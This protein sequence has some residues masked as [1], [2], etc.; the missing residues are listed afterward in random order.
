MASQFSESNS[1]DDGAINPIPTRLYQV[2]IYHN[3]DRKYPCLVVIGFNNRKTRLLSDQCRKIDWWSFPTTAKHVWSILSNTFLA[4]TNSL[5]GH[6]HILRRDAICSKCSAYIRGFECWRKFKALYLINCQHQ[7]RVF[8]HFVMLSL[9]PSI[10]D[11]VH[12]N[13]NFVEINPV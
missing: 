5:K 9:D 3:G 4:M 8:S 13:E 11:R 6:F 12:R 10:R 1:W 2:I 7:I